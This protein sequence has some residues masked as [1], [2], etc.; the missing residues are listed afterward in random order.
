[1]TSAV[2]ITEHIEEGSELCPT[3][4]FPS[5]MPAEIPRWPYHI[6][7]STDCSSQQRILKGE[8]ME[9]LLNDAVRVHTSL[10]N[11][12][13]QVFDIFLDPHLVPE[14]VWVMTTLALASTGCYDFPLTF[15][16]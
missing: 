8:S 1:V 12:R 6:D 13:F 16:S 2:H 9:R 3:G 11:S 4:L 10:L 5:G 15:V 7:P 14:S